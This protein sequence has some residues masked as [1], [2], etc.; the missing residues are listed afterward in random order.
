MSK[1]EKYAI[2]VDL[3]GTYIKFGV[4][5][6]KGKIVRKTFVDT[7]A[8]GGPESVLKQM[9]KGLKEMLNQN[10]IKIF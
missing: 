2:G 10:E 9:K 4:V 8:E 1:L 7:K 3:G 6:E 5:T